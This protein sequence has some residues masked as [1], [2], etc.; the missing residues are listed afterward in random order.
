MLHLIAF[1][2]S[3]AAN[4]A[5]TQCN[6]L[7]SEFETISNNGIIIGSWP[8]ILGATAYSAHLSR[9]QF[10]APSLQVPDYPLITPV[11]VARPTSAI[12]QIWTNWVSG[13]P[14][15]KVGEA[16]LAYEQHSTSTEH[17]Y[18]IA[19]LADKVPAPVNVPFRTMRL[20][21][22]TTLTA[23]AWSNC[24]MTFDDQLPF[25]NYDIVGARNEGASPIAAR[26]SFPGWPSRP[27]MPSVIAAKPDDIGTDRLF[28]AGTLGVWGTFQSTQQCTLE[29]L[30]TAADTAQTLYL[31]LVGPK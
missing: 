8:M 5:L 18:I 9:A 12:H 15:V 17:V 30:A 22:T 19:L 14:T 7:A 29:V 25:G 16:L 13:P 3:D 1:D 20:T 27:A 10:R 2:S 11:A 6:A 24:A 23:D 21:G 28:R 26:L 31:D 4:A